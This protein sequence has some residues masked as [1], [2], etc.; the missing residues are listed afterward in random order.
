MN[1]R[2]DLTRTGPD[3][4]EAVAELK[5]KIRGIEESTTPETMS[6][7]QLMNWSDWNL[8]LAYLLHPNCEEVIDWDARFDHTVGIGP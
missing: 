2:L 6:D 8:E 1:N 5:E 7:Q 3:R 4:I